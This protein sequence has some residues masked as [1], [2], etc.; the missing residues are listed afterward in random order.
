MRNQ[1]LT[2]YKC[3]V[4]RSQWLLMCGAFS[5]ERM[6]QVPEIEIVQATSANQCENMVNTNTFLS[7]YGTN[8]GVAMNTETVFRV[9]ELGMTH[10]ESSG[11]I[12][13]QADMRK[14]AVAQTKSAEIY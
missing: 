7:S 4:L 14:H 2:G 3:K 10:T 9:N 13:C 12:W 11:K 1:V 8:H 5:H 6:I